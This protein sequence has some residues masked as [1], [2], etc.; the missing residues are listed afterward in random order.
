MAPRRPVAFR[1]QIPL[2]VVS[3]VLLVV[4]VLAVVVVLVQHG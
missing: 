4:G 3:V 1:E 2:A